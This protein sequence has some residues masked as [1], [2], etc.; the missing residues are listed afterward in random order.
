M[1]KY[2]AIQSV[3]SLLKIFA[4][5]V[6]FLSLTAGVV[7]FYK[8]E[9]LSG[10]GFGLA[11]G[12]FG[13]LL[14]LLLRAAAESLL[15]LVDIERNTR[16]ALPAASQ[17]GTPRKQNFGNSQEEERFM[18]AIQSNDIETMRNLLKNGE[19]S[20]HGNNQSGRGWLQFGTACNAVPAC[21]LLLELGANPSRPDGN[22]NT[23]LEM[24]TS[25]N[26]DE[27]IGIFTSKSQ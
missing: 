14:W 5:I 2:P 20:V 8:L 27:L 13:L 11:V 4:G 18:S 7:S 25:K 16:T 17:S 3:S 12:V 15:V 22:G 10:V 23:A 24:A 19:V 21:V 26:Y 9:G 6:L 1:Q